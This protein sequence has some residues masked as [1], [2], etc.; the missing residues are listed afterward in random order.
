MVRV[1]RRGVRRDIYRARKGVKEVRSWGHEDHV[2]YCRS[3]CS[4]DLRR[5]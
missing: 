3:Y 4:D 5:T 2:E 1:A